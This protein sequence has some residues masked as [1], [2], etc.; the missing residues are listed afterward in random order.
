MGGLHLFCGI[1]G[2]VNGRESLKTGH[3]TTKTKGRRKKEQRKRDLR[4]TQ[5]YSYYR[6]Y[7]RSAKRQT[8]KTNDIQ[9]FGV[10]AIS[11]KTKINR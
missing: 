3:F 2:S 10:E 9:P 11:I 4:L 5:V 7:I 6:I 1:I 8:G